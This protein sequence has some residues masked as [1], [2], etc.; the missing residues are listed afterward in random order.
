MNNKNQAIK[1][2]TSA[3]KA[4]SIVILSIYTFFL[5]IFIL[6][7]FLGVVT[8]TDPSSR[9]GALAVMIYM[10]L[11]IPLQWIAYPEVLKRNSRGLLRILWLGP[12]ISWVVLVLGSKLLFN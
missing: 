10:I 6:V 11:Y 5:S 1:E 3:D 9:N 2:I 7:A 12:F 8:G 4:I